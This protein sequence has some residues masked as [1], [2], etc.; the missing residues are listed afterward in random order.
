MDERGKVKLDP[1]GSLRESENDG[2][3]QIPPPAYRGDEEWVQEYIR[4]F[5]ENP[6]FF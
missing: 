5:G 4:Q 2:K 6:S 3:K 1:N